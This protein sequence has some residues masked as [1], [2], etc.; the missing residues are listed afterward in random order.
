MRFK[1]R[2]IDRELLDFVAAYRKRRKFAPVDPDDV[3]DAALEAGISLPQPDP[4]TLMR[5]A[6]ARAMQRDIARDPQNRP[7]RNWQAVRQVVEVNGEHFQHVLWDKTLEAKPKFVFTSL[8]QQKQ[9]VVRTAVRID[10][11]HRSYNANNKHGATLPELN[12][13]LRED[14]E[15]DRASKEYPDAPPDDE[16]E[17][18]DDGTGV[19]AP[20]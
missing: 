7:M 17:D 4:K 11:T 14:L 5:R 9:A 20:D 16:E 19:L 1:K 3:A 12:W 10:D 13:D 6:I 2:T 18:G 8:Q 15:M